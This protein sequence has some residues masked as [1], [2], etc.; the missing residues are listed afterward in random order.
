[1]EH[2]EDKS[3]K[4]TFNRKHAVKYPFLFD[5][6]IKVF[7]YF[8]TSSAMVKNKIPNK[9][10]LNSLRLKVTYIKLSLIF[11]RKKNTSFTVLSIDKARSTKGFLL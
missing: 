1:M 9:L 10:V 8:T 3:L 6:T 11:K 7:L 5:E 4:N 2:L